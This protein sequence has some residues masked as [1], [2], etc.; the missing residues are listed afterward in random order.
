MFNLNS[1]L[2]T[3]I[4]LATTT[5]GALYTLT[6]SVPSNP[7]DGL[8][9]NAK[10]RAFYAGLGSPS[11]Y[12]PDVVEPN[13]PDYP[14]S[15]TVFAGLLGL[16][17]RLFHFPIRILTKQRQRSFLPTCNF[18][19]GQCANKGKGGCAWRAADLCY[20]G[21]CGRFHTS[22]FC[23]HPQRIISNGMGQR[24]LSL[25]TLGSSHQLGS[26]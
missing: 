3:T 17:V 9:I 7:L 18:L 1:I 15:S 25:L 2:T 22:A 10:G 11:T 4:L 20:P 8:I 6:P 5:H 16:Y 12:C 23:F 14:D 13:C 19:V 21:G 26:A 24:H